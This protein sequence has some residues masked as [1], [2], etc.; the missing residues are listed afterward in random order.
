MKHIFYPARNLRIFATGINASTRKCPQ[1]TADKKTTVGMKLVGFISR[2]N[3]Y[4]LNKIQKTIFFIYIGKNIYFG[5]WKL[6]LIYYLV[7]K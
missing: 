5:L 7:K 4:F 2:A 6:V 3:L 1:M